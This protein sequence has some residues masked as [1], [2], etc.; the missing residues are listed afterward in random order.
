MKK[1]KTTIMAMPAIGTS[2]YNRVLSN[3]ALGGG[4]TGVGAEK[5][6]KSTHK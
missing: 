1:L 2:E 6:K 4:D 3:W 5:L